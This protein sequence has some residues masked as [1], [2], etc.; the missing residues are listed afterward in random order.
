MRIKLRLNHFQA[1]IA[2]TLCGLL[3]FLT[4]LF[5]STLV[6]A[7]GMFCD[8][9]PNH[10]LCI[11]VNNPAPMCDCDLNPTAPHCNPTPVELISF[12]VLAGPVLKWSTASE[13]NN[14][15]FTIERSTNGLDWFD[16]TTV[17]GHGTSPEVNTYTWHERTEVEGLIYYRLSQTDYDGTRVYLS[18][19]AIRVP[20]VQAVYYNLQGQPVTKGTPGLVIKQGKTVS[21]IY[22][23]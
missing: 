22:N 3:L 12:N 23:F 17:E 19:K 10:V 15:Y 2:S 13:Q 4:I 8:I 6:T 7:Q 11:C 5:A 14:N 20:V 1:L 21:K 18:V 16:V 9:N